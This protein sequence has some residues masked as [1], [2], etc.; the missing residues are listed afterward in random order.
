MGTATA[1]MKLTRHRGEGRDSGG[2]RK[3]GVSMTGRG[4][5]IDGRTEANNPDATM[6]PR[7]LLGGAFRPWF[8]SWVQLWQQTLRKAGPSASLCLSVSICE[9]EV[10]TADQMSEEAVFLGCGYT[11]AG[12]KTQSLSHPPLSAYEPV[13]EANAPRGP[14]LD[15]SWPSDRGSGR[16]GGNLKFRGS[17]RGRQRERGRGEGGTERTGGGGQPQAGRRV[18]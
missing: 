8:L 18:P 3:L 9:M 10:N 13:S 14:T 17:E 6:L 15:F 7:S 4:R 1:H 5:W 11:G 16:E 2:R 12:T